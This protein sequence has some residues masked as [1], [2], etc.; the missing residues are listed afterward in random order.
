MKRKIL[1]I[2]VIFFFSIFIFPQEKRSFNEEAKKHIEL[3]I[4]AAQE[5]IW[6]EAAFRW[7]KAT[8]LDPNN[9]AAH[10]NL[11]IAYEQMGLFDLAL[12]EYEIAFKLAPD[13]PP[14]K[15][16]I[17]SFKEAYKIKEK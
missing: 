7:K 8:E 14:I 11:A 10:N 1:L 4:K 12:E 9:A 16:N 15:A 5:G 2:N 3:G 13:E 6:D 17:S